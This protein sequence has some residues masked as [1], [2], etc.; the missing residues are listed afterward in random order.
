MLNVMRGASKDYNVIG[1]GQMRQERRHWKKMI[2]VSSEFLDGRE[3]R[4]F[5][6]E[7]QRE[8]Y[9]EIDNGGMKIMKG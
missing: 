8:K 4:G 1:R 6:D 9:T 3:K 5:K 2:R 7:A